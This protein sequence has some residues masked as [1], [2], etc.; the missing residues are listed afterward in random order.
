MLL[1]ILEYISDDVIFCFINVLITCTDIINEARK[2]GYTPTLSVYRRQHH[3]TG[4][5]SG[6]DGQYIIAPNVLALNISRN[7]L[8]EGEGLAGYLIRQRTLLKNGLKDRQLL[9]EQPA[10]LGDNLLQGHLLLSRYRPKKGQQVYQCQAVFL[11]DEKKVL[12]FTLSSQQA[13]E[14]SEILIPLQT[15][16]GI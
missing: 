9:E 5:L 10:I 12:I 8:N 2:Y 14:V 13:F 6:T 11:R 3:P 4:R 15:V 7:Q 16:R 1:F